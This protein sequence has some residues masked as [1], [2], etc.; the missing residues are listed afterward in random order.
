MAGIDTVVSRLVAVGIVGDLWIDGSFITDK[1]N[2]K[3]TDIVLHV[4]APSMYD[5]GSPEQRETID[6]IIGNLKDT[7][8]QCDSYHLFTYRIPHLLFD[9]GE[10]NRAYWHHKFGFSREI[11]AKGIVIIP[12]PD[13]AK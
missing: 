3:D 9:E 4:D 8:L 11:E 7:P 1:I 10:W 13:G 2:P 12:I 6:W 5:Y